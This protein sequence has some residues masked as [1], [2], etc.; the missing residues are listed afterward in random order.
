M[1]KYIQVAVEEGF[2]DEEPS[3][4]EIQEITGLGTT[5]QNYSKAIVKEMS[6]T[7]RNRILERINKAIEDTKMIDIG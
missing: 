1:K 6:D 4:P 3:Y 7:E 5:R 2:L